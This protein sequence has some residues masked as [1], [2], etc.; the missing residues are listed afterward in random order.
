MATVS[1]ATKKDKS[2][3]A[4]Y[5]AQVVI[6][7]DGKNYEAGDPITLSDEQA[8]PLLKV[9]AIEDKSAPATDEQA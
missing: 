4:I 8:E 7:H 5:L 6:N 9:G 3:N 2:S 1:N